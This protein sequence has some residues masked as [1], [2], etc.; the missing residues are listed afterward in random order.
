METIT[1]PLPFAAPD[2]SRLLDISGER[3]LRGG[4]DTGVFKILS[5]GEKLSVREPESV[6]RDEDGL[7]MATIQCDGPL[8]LADRSRGGDP[9]NRAGRR[10]R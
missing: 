8:D 1:L 4:S 5:I 2:E 6:V 3:K 9:Y 10:M 7:A